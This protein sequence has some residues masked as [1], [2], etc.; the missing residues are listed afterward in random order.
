MLFSVKSTTGAVII[1]FGDVLRTTVTP[2][3]TP[4]VTPTVDPSANAYIVGLKY[5]DTNKNG[6]YDTGEVGLPN[7]TIQ[8]HEPQTQLTTSGGNFNFTVKP[9][10]YIISE[11]LKPGYTNTSPTSIKV[12]V[13]AGQVLNVTT[14]FGAF[15]NILT[16][17]LPIP[18]IYCYSAERDSAAYGSCDGY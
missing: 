9:G 17:I 5:Y 10:M 1:N 8:V 12:T 3:A 14:S 15:G 2:T 16:P 11:V 4:T 18:R 6:R 13:T 7:W